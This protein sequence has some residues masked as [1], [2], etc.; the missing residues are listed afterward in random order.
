MVYT[1]LK[2]RANLLVTV[3]LEVCFELEDVN[4]MPVI[5]SFYS[6]LLE[7]NIM[8]LPMESAR[9]TKNHS[10][11]PTTGSDK[12]DMVCLDIIPEHAYSLEAEC[13]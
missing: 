12:I 2:Y 5:F 3:Y 1:S 7:G 8:L 10:Y 4:T 11:I 6:D 13:A 9:V